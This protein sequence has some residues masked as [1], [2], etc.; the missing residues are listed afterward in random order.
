[1]TDPLKEAFA[2]NRAAWDERAC[3][4]VEDA[5]GFYG[6]AAFKAGASSLYPIEAVEIGDVT[7]KRLVH[8]QCHFGL[9][10][11]SL[12]RRGASVTGLD[13]SSE[14]ISAARALAAETNI[15]ATFVEGNVYDARRLIAGH[16]DV[17]YVTWGA[18]NWLP[19]IRA[20]AEVVASLLARNGVLYLAET[21]P[22]K[23]TLSESGDRLVAMTD[24]RTPKDKPLAYEDDGSSEG[25]LSYTGDRLGPDGRQGRRWLHPLSEILGG[26]IAAGLRITMF[27]EH[28]V[29][30]YKG[31]AMMVPTGGKLYRLPDGITRFPLAFSLKAVKP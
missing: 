28:E 4:H 10:T 9:D 7:G 21:H 1:M 30:P 14:A 19:D 8:L 12:A 3:I 31:Y 29:L 26:L 5:S 25:A 24:W 15:A 11:L 6:V 27:N 16:F 13:F 17:V 20:W 22:C 23:M 18:V 2:V